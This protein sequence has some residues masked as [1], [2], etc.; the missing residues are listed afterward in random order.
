[1]AKK[2]NLLD[3]EITLEQALS[4]IEKLKE[5]LK[6]EKALREKWET[7]CNELKKS[8]NEKDANSVIRKFYRGAAKQLDNIAEQ[9]MITP[10]DFEEGGDA[11]ENVLEVMKQGK[12]MVELL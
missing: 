5:D 1:M 2:D 7:A 8:L 9:L 12:A 11:I 4:K 3:L 6:S 10:I